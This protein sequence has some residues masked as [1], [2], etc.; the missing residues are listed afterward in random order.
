MSEHE[1]KTEAKLGDG[2]LDFDEAKLWR[3]EIGPDV[4]EELAS[5]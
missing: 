5:K 1:P 3:G 2:L 4:A